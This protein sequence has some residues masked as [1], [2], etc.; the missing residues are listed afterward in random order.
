MC[1]CVCVLFPLDRVICFLINT[2]T[3]AHATIPHPLPHSCGKSRVCFLISAPGQS[4]Q[5]FARHLAVGEVQQA[6]PPP[7]LPARPRQCSCRH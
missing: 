1:V 5:M 7:P 3:R 2:V 6:A 4:V